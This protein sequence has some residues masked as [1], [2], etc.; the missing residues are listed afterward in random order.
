MSPDRRRRRAAVE[1]STSPALIAVCLAPLPA[2]C[3]AKA[4]FPGPPDA[5]RPGPHAS[6]RRVDGPQR[7]R[8]RAA[9]CNASPTSAG[10]AAGPVQP[11]GARRPG[12]E[13]TDS[14]GCAS[15]FPYARTER[16]A[17]IPAGEHGASS[18]TKLA[19]RG[20]DRATNRESSSGGAELATGRSAR[21]SEHRARRHRT[22]SSLST[23]GCRSPIRGDFY[24][25]WALHL[26]ALSDV[27]TTFDGG[28]GRIAIHGRG[29]SSLR[30]PLGTARSHGCIRIGQ[31]L[32]SAS[33]P[34]TSPTGPRSRSGSHRE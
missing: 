3:R 18:T 1:L 27:L 31:S 19:H 16:R 4:S 28:P 8:A 13:A 23:S 17:W 30:D 20:L 14:S 10:G 12:P 6:W 7:P 22:G 24:G 11:P 15:C 32:R 26:T 33:S 2:E 25:P 29:G 21:S 34:R 9:C 5:T